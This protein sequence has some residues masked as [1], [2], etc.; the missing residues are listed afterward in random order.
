MIESLTEP[1]CDHRCAD[2]E[3]CCELC[4]KAGVDWSDEPTNVTRL[5]LE[6]Q[7]ALRETRGALSDKSRISQELR[8]VTGESTPRRVRRSLT[9]REFAAAKGR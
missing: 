1:L 6:M 3:H 2:D 4:A 8:V 7:E 9:P 5:N